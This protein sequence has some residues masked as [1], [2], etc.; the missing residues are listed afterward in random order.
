LTDGER[1]SDLQRRLDSLPTD[2]ENL[3]WSILKSVNY[4]RISQL[5][6][7]VRASPDSISILE[8]SYAD[9]EDPEFVFKM[10]TTPLPITILASRSELMRRRLNACCKGLLEPQ[11]DKT[12]FFA[13]TKV[14]YLHRTVKDFIQKPDVWD[15]LVTA[16]GSSFDLGLRLSVSRVS[17]LKILHTA[18]LTA[19]GEHSVVY[20]STDMRLRSQ[21][22][23]RVIS[24]IWL[25]EFQGPKEPKIKLRLL[26]ELKSILDEVIARGTFAS[27]P[28]SYAT[29]PVS[30]VT[31]FLHLAVKLQVISYVKAHINDIKGL[32]ESEGLS[33]LGMAV[34]DFHCKVEMYNITEPSLGIVET[35]LEHEA[36]FNG[37]TSLWNYVS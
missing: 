17:G 24:S 9:E 36:G 7:I 6:Q 20:N 18:K 34:A 32:A 31:S 8:L 4:E 3:F 26:E 16:T 22:W 19:L 25:I 14:G 5:L 35:L 13:H 37:N 12:N 29:C 10:P 1:L 15:N 28:M 11:I 21:F 30:G 23:S 27:E 2:L 33:L